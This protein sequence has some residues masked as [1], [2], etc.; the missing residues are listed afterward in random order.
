MQRRE[1]KSYTNIFYSKSDIT[2][3]A[4]RRISAG[5]SVRISYLA[6][7]WESMLKISVVWA[8]YRHYVTEKKQP[9][10]EAKPG[11]LLY[12]ATMI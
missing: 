7:L 10:N 9:N 6:F 8:G 1:S 12:S 5:S 11:M 3:C 4:G 2:C